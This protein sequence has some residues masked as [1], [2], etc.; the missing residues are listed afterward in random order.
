[1]QAVRTA[2]QKIE[3]GGS[4]EDAQAVC[5]PDVLSQLFKWKVQYSSYFIMGKFLLA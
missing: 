1:M 4:L 3:E 5:D 2:L